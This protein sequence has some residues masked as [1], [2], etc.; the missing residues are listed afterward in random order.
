[1]APGLKSRNA[2]VGMKKCPISRAS[3]WAVARV[4]ADAC[5]A[6]QRTTGST[7]L[8]VLPWEKSIVEKNASPRKKLNH[9]SAFVIGALDPTQAIQDELATFS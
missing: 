3:V 8:K 2:N 9:K 4:S 5:G 6:Y 1:M 7:M